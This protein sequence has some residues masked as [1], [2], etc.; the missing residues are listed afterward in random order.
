MSIIPIRF[1]LADMTPYSVCL[2]GE[3]VVEHSQARMEFNS[4]ILKD[5]QTHCLDIMG[6]VRVER[7]ELDG[8]DTDYFV[9]HG[10]TSDGTRGNTDRQRVRY[11][12]RTPVWKWYI[13]WKQH[14]NSTFRQ[15]SKD[16]SG[17][18]PL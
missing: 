18:L 11:Y 5:H 6:D 8:I 13:E 3:P 12:F 17:F 4:H 14:D 2:D 9:H 15:L 10:F 1:E 7:L 16:H